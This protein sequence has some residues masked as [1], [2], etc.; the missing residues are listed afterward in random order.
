MNLLGP[1]GEEAGTRVY[2]WIACQ[3]SE[4]RSAELETAARRLTLTCWARCNG[5]TWLL[6]RVASGG[7]LLCG[8]FTTRDRT[9][10]V[11]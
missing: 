10:P 4:V 3:K 2:K 1:G 9:T 6:G 11:P 8:E 7:P 5:R